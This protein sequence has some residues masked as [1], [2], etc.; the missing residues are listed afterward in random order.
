MTPEDRRMVLGRAARSDAS[1]S[2]VVELI[3][4]EYDEMPCLSLTLPQAA[5]LWGLTVSESEHALSM[6]VQNG[7]L[8]RDTKGCYRRSR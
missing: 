7:F 3:R 2:S 8:L 1:T 5:R 6:L 4:A